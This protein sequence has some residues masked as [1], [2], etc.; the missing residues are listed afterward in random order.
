L[1]YPAKRKK[2]IRKREVKGNIEA[3]KELAF[4]FLSYRSR[5]SEEVRQKLSQAGCAPPDIDGV[6]AR[7]E[8]L[9]YLNDYD[10]AFAMGRSWVEIKCWG[11]SRIRDALVKKGVAPETITAVLRELAMEHDFRRVACRA[12]KSRFTRA[13]ML[14]L[15]GDKMRQRA[16]GHLLRRGFSWSIIADVIDT[17]DNIFG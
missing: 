13:E 12:L 5:S 2:E 1:A 17:G 10:Y 4:R 6:I 3:A 14:K 7:L 9:G 11:P 15:N 8:E 16:I